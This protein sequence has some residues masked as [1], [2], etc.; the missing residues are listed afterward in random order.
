MG[1][2]SRPHAQQNKPE[3]D[4]PLVVSCWGSAPIILFLTLYISCE[5]IYNTIS[6]YVVSY[7][8]FRIHENIMSIYDR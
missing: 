4:D 7:I 1:G 6:L 5:G 2:N 3:E 8:W